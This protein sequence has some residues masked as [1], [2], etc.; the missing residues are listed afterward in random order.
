[1]RV[2][3]VERGNFAVFGTLCHI[4][5]NTPDVRIVWD[6]R[7]AERRS[8]RRAAAHERR[9]HERRRPLPESWDVQRCFAITCEATDDPPRT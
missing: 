8:G 5:Q 4:L 2:V 9:R 3:F 1:M 6:R 7:E